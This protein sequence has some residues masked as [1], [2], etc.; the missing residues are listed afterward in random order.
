MSLAHAGSGYGAPLS[1]H[2]RRPR[3]NPMP[4]ASAIV[5]VWG[6]EA[7]AAALHSSAMVC[8][9]GGSSTLPSWMRQA[10]S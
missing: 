7:N 9:S 1:D 2:N 8:G 3:T 10:G 4:T 5:S 6:R